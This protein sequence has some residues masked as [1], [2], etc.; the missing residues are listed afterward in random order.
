VLFFFYRRYLGSTLSETCGLASGALGL[1]LILDAFDRQRPFIL[2][3]GMIC[4][5]TGL[6]ARPGASLILPCLL[7]AMIWRWRSD[8]GRAVRISAGAACCIA[9]TSAANL[10]VFKALGSEQGMLFSNLVY[11][12]YGTI[13]GGDW[14]LAY[15]DYPEIFKLP[16]GYARNPEQFIVPERRQSLEVLKI[17][18][19][20]VRNHPSLVWKGA[21][22]A[23]AAFLM[24]RGGPFVYIPNWIIEKL[25]MMLGAIGL[26]AAIVQARTCSYSSVLVC[27]AVGIALSL[28]F[29]P[30]WDSDSMRAYAATIPFFA[31]FCACGASAICLAISRPHR[32][33]L[34]SSPVQEPVHEEPAGPAI[35][36]AF[37]LLFLIYLLP[38]GI[39]FLTTNRAP[40]LLRRS[41]EH[42]ELIFTSK[43]GNMVRIVA[44]NIAPTLVPNVRQ[45]DF[46]AGLGEY[47]ST[48]RGEAEYLRQIA[49]YDPVLICPEDANLGFI[50]ARPMGGLPGRPV[51][52][53]GKVYTLE[54]YCAFFVED[55]LPA[56]V[57]GAR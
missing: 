22:R 28:P 42:A 43:P 39:R 26:V 24:N 18:E 21:L 8:L 20:E 23:W 14:T 40:M 50:V 56:P 6:N 1:A 38:V 15:K 51:R 47:A 27:G 31:A 54:D 55:G 29:A 36:A 45:A 52:I 35:P 33:H 5:G 46:L 10:G 30:P 11:S 12:I 25:M 9:I 57:D 2:G 49:P 16:E 34:A 3:L 37:A 32:P 19:L 41:D 44:G 53:H 4:L 13:N 17:V 7:L 48:Y